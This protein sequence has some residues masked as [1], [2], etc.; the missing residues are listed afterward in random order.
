MQ[1]KQLIGEMSVNSGDRA[2]IAKITTN[3]VDRDRE[4]LI[5]QGMHSAD[6]EK[7]P[8]IFWAHEYFRP[9]LGKATALNRYDDHWMARGEM[10]ERPENHPE[11]AEWF[12]DTVLSLMDQGVIRGV[13]GGFDTITS[14]KP[15]PSDRAKYGDRV[16]KV[17][18]KWNLLESSIAPMPANQDALITAVGKGII[19]SA[20]AKAVWGIQP[21]KAQKKTARRRAMIVVPAMPKAKAKPKIRQAQVEK[22]VAAAIAKRCGRIYL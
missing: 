3:A 13:S 7:N 17:V 18:G 19:H 20:T 15:T 6:Y 22:A 14:H 2:F 16:E 21:P 10:A 8:M 9:P 11:A 4:V 5:P 1:S 12:P